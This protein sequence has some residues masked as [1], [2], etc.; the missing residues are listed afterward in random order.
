MKVNFNFDLTK[1]SE[2]AVKVTDSVGKL[3][4][5]TA[6]ICLGLCFIKGCAKELFP[7]KKKHTRPVNFHIFK[8]EE[9]E[10]EKE[11]EKTEEP[12][13]KCCEGAPKEEK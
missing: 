11:E 7:K 3:V 1:A 9:N 4:V 8:I 5:N 10:C 12:L 6:I 2:K 13:T